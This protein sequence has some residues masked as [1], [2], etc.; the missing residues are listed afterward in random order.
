VAWSG[1]TASAFDSNELDDDT[2]LAISEIRAGKDGVS[3]KAADRI[4][5]LT[6]L[7]KHLGLFA[8]E[9]KPQDSSVVTNITN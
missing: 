9:D 4:A 7:S 6:A 2:A 3:I 1:T 8:D 5:A